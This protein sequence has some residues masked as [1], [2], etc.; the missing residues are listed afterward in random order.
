V[1]VSLLHWAFTPVIGGVESH[2]ATL[3][4]EFA[5]AGHRS[6]LLT[7]AVDGLP[8]VEVQE[9]L[10]IHRAAEMS[11]GK[12]FHRLTEAGLAAVF[13]AFLDS[14]RPDVL[15]AHNMHYFSR[16]HLASLVRV[17]RRRGLPLILTAHNVWDDSL[18]WAMCQLSR[19]WDAVIAVSSYIA[20]EL[21]AAG[22]PADRIAVVRH[23]ISTRCFRPL[24]GGERGSLER[25]F[26]DLAR[27][28][29]IFHPART[30]LVKG[31]LVA[32]RALA[33]IHQD[34]P[35]AVL[36]L[37]GM[38]EVVDWGGHRAREISAIRAEA[39]RL[40]VGD[41]VLFRSFTRDE[42][43]KVFRL[44][45][46]TIYPSLNHEPFG[47]AV[48]EA[49]ASASP[50]VVSRSGGMPEFV[51]DGETGFIVPRGDDASLADRIR[52]LLRDERLARHLGDQARAHVER[53]HTARTMARATLDV[54]D[55]A[56]GSVRSRTA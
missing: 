4:S 46:V 51:R 18:W 11:L 1:R 17:A 16:R 24:A 5:A 20:D 30:S 8:E 19:A 49:M 37:A 47:L 54:Y 3:A 32:V 40:G 25:A 55:S 26:P 12:G 7:G 27:R 44:A 56:L 13:G 22:F 33:R 39:E 28:P 21:I 45:A 48:L 35:E 10:E 38:G 14:S 52:L 53:H 2:L 50:V 15:H 31:S 6:W 41:A 43:A 23:G 36:V 34:V 9:T 42:M 29:V